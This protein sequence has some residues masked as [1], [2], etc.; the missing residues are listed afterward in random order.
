MAAV[1]R[2]AARRCSSIIR[3]SRQDDS[4]SRRL[5]SETSRKGKRTSIQ[6]GPRGAVSTNV[7][8]REPQRRMPAKVVEQRAYPCSH[9]IRTD[10]GKRN[11]S[12]RVPP[13]WQAQ[14]CSSRPSCCAAPVTWRTTTETHVSNFSQDDA[15]KPDAATS[16][17]PVWRA[18]GGDVHQRWCN[19]PPF[20]PMPTTW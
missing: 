3:A 2:R 7:W 19:A 16:A 20:D 4:H 11:G 18:L 14:G 13:T 9:I 1:P 10:Y 17:R 15:G 12:K 6:D 5:P 8:R